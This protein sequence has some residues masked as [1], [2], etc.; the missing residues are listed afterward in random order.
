MDQN[1]RKHDHFALY[2]G[3]ANLAPSGPRD[4][5]LVVLRGSHLLHGQHF[6]AA[7]GFRPEQDTGEAEDGYTFTPGDAAWYR[8]RGCDEVKVCAGEGDL[9]VWDSRLVHWN[10]SPVGGRVRFAA[11]VC[12][13]PRSLMAE[14]DLARKLE[15]FRARKCTTHWPVSDEFW[16]SMLLE[17]W[18]GGLSC[19]CVC[20]GIGGDGG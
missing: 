14:G 11:Y 2:Q 16:V 8:A 10:A 17:P 18:L 7:G 1:P 20:V 4:G 5:G 13:C 12:Y 15:V 9:I 19:V 6:S 3:I